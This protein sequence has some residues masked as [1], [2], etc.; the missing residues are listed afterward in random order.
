MTLLS[1]NAPI[2]NYVSKVSQIKL[3]LGFNII[4]DRKLVNNN[5]KYQHEKLT[6]MAGNRTA[7]L[8]IT[9][10]AL[11][12]TGHAKSLLPQNASIGNYFSSANI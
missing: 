3:P 10:Q 4:W 6:A 7:G 11:H 8:L 2:E 12:H 9:G 1:Q 5:T